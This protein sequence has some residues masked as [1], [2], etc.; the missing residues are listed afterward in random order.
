MANCPAT[1]STHI[2]L[3]ANHSPLLQQGRQRATPAAAV[4]RA[5]ALGLPTGTGPRGVGLGCCCRTSCTPQSET[6]DVADSGGALP[7]ATL[8]SW[9]GPASLPRLQ[10]HTAICWHASSRHIPL[11]P[12]R[13]P[14]AGLQQQAGHT[15]NSSPGRHRGCQDSNGERWP[16]APLLPARLD[17]RGQLHGAQVPSAG[18]RHAAC[19]W[20]GGFACTVLSSNSLKTPLGSSSC[21]PFATALT[22]A[23]LCLVPVAVMTNEGQTDVD[24]KFRLSPE[25]TVRGCCGL[26]WVRVLG[27]QQVGGCCLRPATFLLCFGE[28]VCISDTSLSLC[29]MFLIW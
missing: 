25:E 23:V 2:L 18:G 13:P 29:C 4:R 8:A 11:P 7:A 28:R 5:D 26:G 20:V 27:L 10:C 17:R 15:G 1:T 3:V 12:G 9:P 21:S 14:A 22:C 24:F 6:C 16:R 19:G